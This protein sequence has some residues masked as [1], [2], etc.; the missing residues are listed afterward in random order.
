[1]LF[2]CLTFNVLVL[3]LEVHHVIT[4]VLIMLLCCLTFNV[5]VLLLEVHHVVTIVLIVLLML[6]EIQCIVIVV[7]HSSCSYCCQTFVST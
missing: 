4:I 3:L 6:L 7:K 1:M 2:C 5:L